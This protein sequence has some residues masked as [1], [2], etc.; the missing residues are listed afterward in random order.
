MMTDGMIAC[1]SRQILASATSTA[2]MFST[3]AI[4]F[5]ATAT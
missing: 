1:A 4:A 3:R 5:L 2:A